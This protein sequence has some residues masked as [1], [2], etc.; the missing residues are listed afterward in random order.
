MKKNEKITRPL[1]HSQLHAEAIA[2]QWNQFHKF[3]TLI[4]AAGISWSL[5]ETTRLE[6]ADPDSLVWRSI[7]QLQA[8]VTAKDLIATETLSSTQDARLIQKMG[9]DVYLLSLPLIS[10]TAPQEKDL[11]QLC[12]AQKLT[13]KSSLEKDPLH[14]KKRILVEQ[15]INRRC[16][17]SQLFPPASR[18]ASLLKAQ[19]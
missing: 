1:V 14:H 6:K 16:G 19:S 7:L 5:Q 3:D 11:Q 2:T 18:K 17:F 12:Q 10:L 15:E 4:D 9:G 13:L 8:K